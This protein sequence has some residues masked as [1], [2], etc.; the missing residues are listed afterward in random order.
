MSKYFRKIGFKGLNQAV[1]FD[2]ECATIEPEIK[3]GTD[4]WESWKYK[5]R[6]EEVQDL[7]EEFKKKGPLYLGFTKIVCMVLGYFQGDEIITKSYTGE[8]KDL[9]VDFMKDFSK[10]VQ[11]GKTHLV[12]FSGNGYDIP[13]VS[14]RCMVNGIE[15]HPYFDVAC[16][17]EWNMEYSIDLNNYLRGTAF[18]NLSLINAAVAFGLPSPKQ[19]LSGDEVSNLYWD[20]DKKKMEKIS[21]YCTQDVQVTAGILKK[22]VLKGDKIIE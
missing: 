17:K 3:E 4:L 13:A 11:S 5:M 15:P 10:L 7:N 19:S 1:V 8:E 14:F 18:T 2:I 16:Q 22:I 9:L 6:N 20:K 21:D 12:S